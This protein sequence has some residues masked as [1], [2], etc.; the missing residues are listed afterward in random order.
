MPF[1]R[2]PLPH[3]PPY[4]DLNGREAIEALCDWFRQ[5]ISSDPLLQPHLTLPMARIA[6]AIDISI[7]MY[8]GGSVPIASPPDNHSIHREGMIENNLSAEGPAVGPDGFEAR[9][10]RVAPSEHRDRTLQ[11]AI[12]AAPIPG[13]ELPDKIRE[14][15]NL[16][17]PGPGYGDRETGRHLFVGDP[18]MPAQEPYRFTVSRPV[19]QVNEPPNQ[20]E[21]IR[22]AGTREGIVADGYKFADEV[23]RPVAVQEIPVG[24]GEIKIDMTGQG[25]Q[26]AG[27]TVKERDHRASVKEFG[28]ER[29]DKY[30]SVNGVYD[31]GPAGLMGK[32]SRG[33]G[34]LGGDGRQR[35]SFGN[36]QRG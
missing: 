33:G 30:S 23:P 19:P 18:D 6:L 15:H 5:A 14:K 12:N 8:I 27:M 3:R 9:T 29:G 16:P 25:I 2:Q 36:S 28:D 1:Q 32:A 35:I 34:G 4:N 22:T 31:A 20:A 26:H 24:S 11:A 21:R 10:G 17:I 13:G 7:D